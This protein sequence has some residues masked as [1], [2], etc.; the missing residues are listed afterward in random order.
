MWTCRPK[1]SSPSW[2]RLVSL[3]EK[4]YGIV[5]HPLGHTLSPLLHNAGF[6]RVGWPGKYFAWPIPPDRLAAFIDAVRLLPVQGVSVTIPHKEAVLP[7]LDHVTPCARKVGAVNT[8]FWQ[9]GALCGDN[10]DVPGFLVPLDDR[11]RPRTA[12][13]LGAGG[14]ARGVLAALGRLGVPRIRI[15]TR[16]AAKAQELAAEFGAEALAWEKRALESADM[17]INATPLGMRGA[18]QDESPFPSDGFAG[19]GLAYDLVYN[20]LETRFL[21]E[22]RA[23]GWQ[24]QDGLDML[25]GQGLAQFALWTGTQLDAAWARALLANALTV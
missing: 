11:P 1:K 23:A 18:R 24:T 5:G 17:I 19:T 22:A 14:A 4:L 2:N 7:L 20:P 15:A 12:L 21:R 8:L 13:V 16:N 25:V 10:T 3:P 6:D 9:D